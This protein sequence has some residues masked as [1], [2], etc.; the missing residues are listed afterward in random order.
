M[1]EKWWIQWH[2]IRSTYS[3]QMHGYVNT[4]RNIKVYSYAYSRAFKRV[5]NA[6]AIANAS[7]NRIALPIRNAYGARG[8]SMCCSMLPNI[9]LCQSMPTAA[10]IWQAMWL[11]CMCVSNQNVNDLLHRTS[12]AASFLLGSPFC[13]QNLRLFGYCYCC[14]LL[15]LSVWYVFIVII[16]T[17]YYA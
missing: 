13:S 8:G 16:L 17:K 10:C 14:Y 6:I 5:A 15:S 4:I 2:A 3:T 12:F 11:M 7:N 1:N 9:F